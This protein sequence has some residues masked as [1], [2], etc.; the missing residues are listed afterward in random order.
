MRFAITAHGIAKQVGWRMIEDNW[1][2]AQGETFTVDDDG[3]GGA[4]MH[5]MVL[6]DDGVSIRRKTQAEMDA[7]VQATTVE[8]A[9]RAGIRAAPDLIDLRNRLRTATAAQI[10][11][12]VDNNITDPGTR[13]LFK[14]AFKLLAIELRS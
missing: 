7:E 1:S 6:G 10:D 5:N 2:L 11:T 12:Y 9:R 14:Q 4:T 13:K 8:Q 3:V